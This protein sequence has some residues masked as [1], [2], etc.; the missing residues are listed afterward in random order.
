VVVVKQNRFKN[1]PTK[2][3]NTIKIGGEFD[4]LKPTNSFTLTVINANERF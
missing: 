3:N 1:F 2:I 4:Q